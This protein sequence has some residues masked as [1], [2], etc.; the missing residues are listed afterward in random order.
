MFCSLFDPQHL[1]LFVKCNLVGGGTE[2]SKR[3]RIFS[4]NKHILITY[5]VPSLMLGLVCTAIKH[6]TR[7]LRRRLQT[8]EGNKEDTTRDGF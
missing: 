4:F 6:R 7:I 2:K 5:S 3:N 8:D 1:E